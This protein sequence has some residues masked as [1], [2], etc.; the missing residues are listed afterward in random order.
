[1]NKLD[2]NELQVFMR[3]WGGFR[4][5]R[6]VLTANNLRIFEYTTAAKT[7]K[8]LSRTITTDERATTI[9]LDACTALGLLKKTGNRYRNTNVAKQFLLP[10][11]PFY[12]GDMLRHADALWQSWSG[13]DEVVRT[14]KPNRSGRRQHDVFI[15]AMHNSAA[16]RVNDVMH[17]LDLRT[18]KKA[19][20]LGGGPGTYSIALAKQGIA[21]TLFD[22][23]DTLD[24]SREI[25]RGSGARNIDLIAGDFHFDDIGS[26][27]DLVFISQILH[28]HSELENEAL[29]TKVFGSL[30][31]GGTAVIHEFALD[32]TRAFPAAGAL[33]SVN[34]LVNTM[35]GRCYAPEE[36]KPWMVKAG[37]TS[38]KRTSLGD[39]VLISGKKPRRRQPR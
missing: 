30:A 11:S 5:A 1:M 20:D 10:D 22:L 33:F 9:L 35:S 27:Y 21:V 28:S 2:K 32:K 3:L 13:L 16:L 4:P 14:G 26:G 19:L 6:I 34:M 18:I 23:P 8:E 24:V 17:A 12:Q 25:I 39:T 37:F 36:M 7:A 38:V 29:L 31:D 15:R